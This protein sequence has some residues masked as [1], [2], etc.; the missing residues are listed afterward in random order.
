MFIYIKFRPTEC[1]DAL[2]MHGIDVS[3]KTRVDQLCRILG[4]EEARLDRGYWSDLRELKGPERL[5]DLKKEYGGNLE[6][7]VGRLDIERVNKVFPDFM[8]GY[9]RVKRENGL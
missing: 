1:P 6:Y 3:D 5:S 8:Q 7:Y 9:L 2:V 4:V